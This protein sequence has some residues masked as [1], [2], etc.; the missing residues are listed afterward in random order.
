[1][2]EKEL[3]QIVSLGIGSARAKL[4]PKT[5]QESARGCMANSCATLDLRE[6]RTK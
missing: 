5:K 4:A 1:M 3:P 2:F 6:E